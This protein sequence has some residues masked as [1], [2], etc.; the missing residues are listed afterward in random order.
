M[1]KKIASNTL[2]QVGS[3]AGTA[4]I[5]IFLIS[6][7]TNYLTIELYGLYSK[8]YNYIG[9]F[10]FLADLGLYAIAIRE[11]SANK[12]DSEKIVGNVMSLRLILGIFVLF[13]AV[14]IAY[15]LPGYNSD[16]ALVS[17]FIASIFTIFQLLNSSILALMQA[18]MRIEFSLFSTVFGKLINVLF[19]VFIMYVC[20]NQSYI[21]EGNSTDKIYFK[22]FVFI[23]IAG[24]IG[25]IVNTVLNFW[26]ARRIVN[27]RFHFDLEYIKYIFKISL[28]YGI[29]L[30]L[31]VVYFKV[32]VILLSLIKGPIDGDASIALYSLPM[33]IVEVIMVV[34]GFYLNSI[35][36]SLTKFFEENKQKQLDNLIAISFKILFGSAM[37]VFTLGIL[38]R[39]YLIEIIANKDYLDPSYLYNSSDAFLVVFAVVLFYFI[40]LV[41]IYTLVA[42]KNQSKLLYINIIVTLFNIVGNIIL[43]PKYSFMG[44]GIVT[45][46]SQILLMIL[47]YFY[48]RKLITFSLPSLFIMKNILFGAIIYFVG[49]YI[50]AH[51]S[52]GLYLDVIIYG[53]GL[54]ILYSGFL[55]CEF[56]AEKKIEV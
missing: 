18:N 22:P 16:L 47:G 12:K 56:R 49:F 26:Y 53:T 5:S 51:F 27:I 25:V 38:F 46:L 24:V 11:I 19:V 41:F 21:L 4:I 14:G 8:V 35:L 10:V 48:T 43:I 42:S 52:L 17:I 45:L 34:G 20:Y 31:S 33:K 40:S 23:M 36:P 7:L 2:S 50:L 6:I 15:F 30:F 13:F 3:K 9:I 32:D 37:L 44:A 1:F 28:P 29:A 39:D 55:Y 54:F